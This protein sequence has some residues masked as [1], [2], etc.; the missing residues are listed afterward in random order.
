MH[1]AFLEPHAEVVKNLDLPMQPSKKVHPGAGSVGSTER[2]IVDNWHVQ[3]MV[4]ICSS[5]SM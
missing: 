1:D 5:L 4:L 3:H 2:C